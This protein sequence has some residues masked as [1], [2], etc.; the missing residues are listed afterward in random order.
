MESEHEGFWYPKVDTNVCNN[1]GQCERVCPLIEG[2]TVPVER[3]T[4]P[5]ALA[6]WNADPV[7]RLDSTS[8]GVFSALASRMF[9]IGGNVA[10]AVYEKDHTVSHV[11]TSDSRMLDALRSS[12]YLQSYVGELFNQIKQL[13]E[14]GKQVLICGTPCQIA[15]LYCVL[16]KDYERLIT[17][18]FICRGVNSPKAFL[19]YI[20][21]LERKYGAQATRIKFK[22][23]TFGWHRFATRID[24]AN[25]KTYIE[26]RYHDLFM[27]GYLQHNCFVR[28]SCYNCR[29][30][31]TP[32]Q[33]KL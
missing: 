23:K 1:C 13:L 28:P 32:R 10:G 3:L 25:G 7:V 30:K 27:V 22:N 18:D 5:R 20:E 4:L 24:F 12:K 19:K 16:G 31:G 2:K 14:N 11:L 15:G 21:M 26:D 6:V 17:C 9:Q 29:F 33:A 8:G